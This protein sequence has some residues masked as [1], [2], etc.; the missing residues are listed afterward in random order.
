MSWVFILVYDEI[1][2]FNLSKMQHEILIQVTE[3]PDEG[4]RGEWKSWL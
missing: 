1:H 4:E 2:S 3:P